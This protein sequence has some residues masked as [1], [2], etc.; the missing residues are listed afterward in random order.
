MHVAHLRRRQRRIAALALAGGLV[1]PALAE[2][3]LD[4]GLD[5]LR[6]EAGALLSRA[7]PAAMSNYL[8]GAA[9]AQGFFGDFELR[10]GGRLDA[11]QQTGAPSF[12]HARLDYADSFVRYR[13]EHTRLTVGAQTVTWGRVDEIP[14]TDRLSVLDLTRGVLDEYAQRRR[15]VPALRWERFHDGYKLDL[16]WIPRF[17]AAQLPRAE[18]IWHPVDRRRGRLLGLESDPL[19]AELVRGGSFRDENRRAGEGG[20]R[21]SGAGRALDYGVTVQRARHSAPY[22]G[23]DP[24][25]R[26]ALLAGADPAAALTLAPD[27]AFTGRHPGTWVLGGDVALAGAR[28]TWRAE[29]AYLSDVPVTT[30]DL[31]FTTVAAFEWVAGVEFFPGDREL[32]VTL[33][34]AGRNLLDAP[35]VLDRTRQYLLTGELEDFYRLGRWRGRMRFLLGLDRRDLYVNPEIAYIGGEPHEFY[36]GL[37]YFDGAPD[38]LGGFYRE[39]RMIV[40][41]WRARF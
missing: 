20:V 21:L 8:H 33:Q 41:G 31:R 19:L 39:N 10:L 35:P 1:A 25:V 32:R 18:S 27:G 11:Y 23:L 7:Q 12:D 3:P 2:G 6:V 30:M 24:A 40:A 13:G 29:A 28:A 22:Y 15:A 38:T 4:V 36:L 26:A 14:P 34:L 17:R 37:H 16:L 5:A 9:R